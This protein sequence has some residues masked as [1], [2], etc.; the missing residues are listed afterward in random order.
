[1][2]SKPYLSLFSSELDEL[3]GLCADF[4][5]EHL[6]SVIPTGV[7]QRESV[8]NLMKETPSGSYSSVLKLPEIAS[9]LQSFSTTSSALSLALQQPKP[10]SHTI[11]MPKN[12]RLSNTKCPKEN[13]YR[14]ALDDWTT[15]LQGGPTSAP[16]ECAARDVKTGV[17][18]EMKRK[19]ISKDGATQKEAHMHSERKRRRSMRDQFATLQSLIPRRKLMRTDRITVL[20]EVITYIRSMR[21]RLEE[22]DSKKA[23]ILALL[24]VHRSYEK[25]YGTYERNVD[26]KIE[27][28]S[29]LEVNVRLSGGDVFVIL[30][31]PKKRGLWSAV[32]MLLQ[33]YK[34]EVVNASLASSEENNLHHIH[35]KVG[36]ASSVDRVKLQKELEDVIMSELRR[37]PRFS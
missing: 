27:V 9:A 18:N 28:G 14:R 22:L 12:G 19:I 36:N 16:P 26:A 15:N 21:R 7:L 33:R 25:D 5:L 6:D 35:G 8:E 34:V 29:P 10:G 13:V 32:L 4:S 24:S 37:R 2:D 17:R 30:N 23:D 3:D 20:I 11:T 31:T 1:M